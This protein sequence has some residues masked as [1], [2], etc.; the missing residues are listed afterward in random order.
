MAR[1]FSIACAHAS[2]ASPD[3]LPPQSARLSTHV[4]HHV[5]RTPRA[6]PPRHHARRRYPS[7]ASSLV[8]FHLCHTCSPSTY[9]T[10][11]CS[12]AHCP[13]T[14]IV[15][16]PPCICIPARSALPP[17]ALSPPPAL[18][19]KHLT[20][21][22]PDLTCYHRP[23]IAGVNA[24]NLVPCSLVPLRLQDRV[25]APLAREAAVPCSC[26]AQ[27]CPKIQR[28]PVLQTAQVPV[29]IRAPNLQMPVRTPRRRSLALKAASLLSPSR[30]ASVKRVGGR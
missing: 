18:K 1:G 28:E 27:W 6:S 11:P 24:C 9:H 30:L 29:E 22:R 5:L 2:A 4:C 13:L 21:P 23:G 25:T 14:L 16:P 7:R 12:V 15:A 3:P 8:R 20:R 17:S 10:R 26:P 19:F